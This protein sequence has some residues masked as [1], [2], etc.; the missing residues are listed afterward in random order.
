RASWEISRHSTKKLVETRF[1]ATHRLP[2]NR[3][4]WEISRHSTK[5]R[6]ETRFLATHR[7]SET[8][9]LGRFLVTQPKNS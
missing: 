9:F 3:V 8:G 4:S 2:R 6:V 5:K 7:L 1:L